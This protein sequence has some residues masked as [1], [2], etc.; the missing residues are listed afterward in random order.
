MK[1][2]GTIFIKDN[3]I[4]IDKPRKRNTYQMIGGR[5]EE[6]E[7]PLQ[8]AIRECHEELGKKAIFDEKNFKELMDFEEIA[9]SDPNLKIHFHVFFYQGELEG[10]LTTSEEIESFLWYESNLGNDILSNTLKNE[11]VPY[12]LNNNLIK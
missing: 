1:V 7:T 10:E 8:A 12:C 4:L 3:K 9:T 5:V 2:V 6:N 11:V